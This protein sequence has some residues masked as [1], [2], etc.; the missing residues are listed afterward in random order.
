MLPEG[1]HQISLPVPFG[2]GNVNTWLLTGEPLTLVDAGPL[3][4]EA[5]AALDA[6]T[7]R[8]RRARSRTSS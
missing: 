1:I 6:G 3:M 7:G 5:E 8:A 2:V 4:D